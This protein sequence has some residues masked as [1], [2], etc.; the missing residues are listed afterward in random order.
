MTDYNTMTAQACADWL[1]ERDGWTKEIDTD[2]QVSWVQ[3][4]EKWL[5]DERAINMTRQYVHPMPM[6][7]DAAAAALRE[8]WDWDEV[9]WYTAHIEA[10]VRNIDTGRKIRTT[11]PDELTARYRAAVAARM[12]DDK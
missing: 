4:R 8:P 7:L 11:A 10:V 1:A 5:N 6:T 12:E 3:H 9:Q 2:G